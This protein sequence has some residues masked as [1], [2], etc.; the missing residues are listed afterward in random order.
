MAGEAGR[1]HRSC[2]TVAVLLLLFSLAPGLTCFSWRGLSKKAKQNKVVS[3]A[4]MMEGRTGSILFN[5]KQL[6]SQSG[7][8]SIAATGNDELLHVDLD[9]SDS[10]GKTWLLRFCYFDIL[11]ASTT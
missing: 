1:R 5:G 2:Q 4:T 3:E 8:P 7:S 9:Q 6:N 11:N 10:T